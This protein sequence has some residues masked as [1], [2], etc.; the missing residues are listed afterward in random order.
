MPQYNMDLGKTSV[1][2]RLLARLDQWDKIGGTQ[3]I[4]KGAQPQWISPAAPLFL[5]SQ[6]QPRQFRGN[7]EQEKEYMNQLEK[8]FSSGI[9]KE[10]DNAQV[11]NPTFLVPYQDGRF[12][13]ILYCRKINLLT[14][15][16]HFK[17]DGPEELRQNLQE[18]DYAKIL[19]IKDAFH[20]V[21]VSPNLQ[22]FLEF[23]FKNKSYTY[24]GLPFGWRRSPLLLSKTLAIAIRAIR[25]KWKVKIQNYMDEI[26][27]IHQS[28]QQLKPMILEIISFLTNLGQRLSPT[29]CV[30][31]PKKCFQ[32]LG[33]SFQTQSMEVIM[34]QTRRR[35]MKYKLKDCIQMTN[36]S[37]IVTIRSFA[38]LIGEINYLRFQFPQVSL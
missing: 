38:S 29:K 34:T 33:W 14:Q 12:R 35:S 19:D 4:S 1:P 15:P 20:H 11:Y 36:E 24:L 22:P 28:K 10:M 6:Q 31:T 21:H 16:V 32:Y 26:I 2:D 7:L 9:V 37:Q 3:T 5:Q 23:Q 13:K 25:E 27:L 17:M 18:S 30:L 8:E